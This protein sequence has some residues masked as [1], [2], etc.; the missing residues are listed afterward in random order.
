MAQ[1]QSSENLNKGTKTKPTGR[2][3]WKRNKTQTETHMSLEWAL[4]TVTKEE[5]QKQPGLRRPLSTGR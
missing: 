1:R 4:L 2:R 3:G 5:T